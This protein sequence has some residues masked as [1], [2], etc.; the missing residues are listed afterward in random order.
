VGQLRSAIPTRCWNW[1]AEPHTSWSLP[2]DARRIPNTQTAKQVGAEQIQALA[3][4]RSACLESLDIIAADGKYG[5]SGFLRSVKGLRCGILARL[6]CDRVLYALPPPPAP[7]KRG[8]H[9]MHGKRFAF[10]EPE[11]WGT[12]TEV[13]ELEDEHWGKVRLEHWQQLH[14]KKGADVPYDVI[15]ACVHL[16]REKPPATLWLAWLAPGQFPA[17]M[18]VNA[19]NHL[20]SLRFPLAGRSRHPFP[21]RNLGLDHA[22]LSDQ[23]NRGSL[24]GIDSASLLDDFPGSPNC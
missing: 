10:K 14:E 12:P 19:R 8:R 22:P 6:R 11:T 16:E 17:G 7:H 1:C 23:R 4:T 2:I 5:N 24:D 18:T 21:Q 20:A 13:V 9:K 3:S 15:R